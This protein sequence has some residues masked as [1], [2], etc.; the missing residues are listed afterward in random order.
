MVYDYFRH[1]FK[2]LPREV[3]WRLLSSGV[4]CNG[5][6][7]GASCTQDKAIYNLIPDIIG[8]M[9]SEEE[10]MLLTPPLD[11]FMCFLQLKFCSN[12]HVACWRPSQIE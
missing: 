5:V 7:T 3:W 1:R 8:R 2:P 4:F 12:V 9:S 6:Q 10:S 11:L